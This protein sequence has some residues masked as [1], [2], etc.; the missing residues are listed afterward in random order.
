MVVT[1]P[2]ANCLH[3]KWVYKT[4]RDADGNLGR[5]KARLVA[6]GNEQ[7][8]DLDYNFTFAAVVEMSSEKFISALARVVRVPAQHGDIPNAY[9]K[10]DKEPELDIP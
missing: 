6:C 3:T 9:V 10:A 5:Y 7:V 4:K 8:F 2:N 1:P